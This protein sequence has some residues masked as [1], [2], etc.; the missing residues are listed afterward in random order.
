MKLS[1][2]WV[3]LFLW[4]TSG[5]AYAA[6]ECKFYNGDTRQI[7]SPAHSRSLRSSLPSPKQRLLPAP[8]WWNS[9]R[10]WPLIAQREMTVKTSGKWRITR[11]WRAILPME[12]RCSEPIFRIEYAIAM[13]P[14]GQGVIGWFPTD[15]GAYYLT[16][17]SHDN[18]DML[19]EKKWHTDGYLPNARL[20]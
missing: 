11:C 9:H 2:L 4:A 16:G 6:K 3:V 5:A 15:A 13:Y 17:N 14:T 8:L 10:K 20:Y 18:E 19:D 1:P 7:M 12:R